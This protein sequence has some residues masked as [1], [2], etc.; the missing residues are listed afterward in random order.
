M[1]MD[2]ITMILRIISIVTIVLGVLITFSVGPR[3][4][5][6]AS[7][8]SP[9]QE[10]VQTCFDERMACDHSY[11]EGCPCDACKDTPRPKATTAERRSTRASMNDA[12]MMSPR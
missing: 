2:D 4:A 12:S 3:Q 1:I 5:S 7:H 6:A 8:A 9:D 10:K 11:R